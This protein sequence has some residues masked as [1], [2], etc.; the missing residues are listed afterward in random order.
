MTAHPGKP[1]FRGFAARWQDSVGG[2]I[3]VFKIVQFWTETLAESVYATG[4]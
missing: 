1:G 4:K 2:S 3:I